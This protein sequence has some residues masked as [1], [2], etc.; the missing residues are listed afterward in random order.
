MRFSRGVECRFGVAAPVGYGHAMQVGAEVVVPRGT[1]P[2]ESRRQVEFALERAAPVG[3][4]VD[5]QRLTL[6]DIEQS[7]PTREVHRWVA[8]AVP[9]AVTRY[10][11]P[12]CDLAPERQWV[13]SRAQQV[14]PLLEHR[15]LHY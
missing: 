15:P 2:E 12:V 11:A 4:E 3:Y 10:D 5:P 9:V 13:N 6:A 1:A 8:V 14:E 7:D